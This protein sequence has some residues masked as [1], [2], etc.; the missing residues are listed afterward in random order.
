LTVPQA[1]VPTGTWARRGVLLRAAGGLDG[2][3]D[4]G[5]AGQHGPSVTNVTRKI[6]LIRLTAIDR[7][8]K[9]MG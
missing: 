7:V 4:D 6:T 1:A 3:L 5:R 8:S 2:R 9:A